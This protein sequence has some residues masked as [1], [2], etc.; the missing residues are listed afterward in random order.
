MNEYVNALMRPI[1]VLLL[2]RKGIFAL[3]QNAPAGRETREGTRGLCV[4]AQVSAKDPSATSSKLVGLMLLFVCVAA[5]PLQ[6]VEQL[7]S[8]LRDKMSERLNDPFSI[9]PLEIATM[10][11]R[12]FNFR[13]IV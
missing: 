11:L 12:H 4:W 2:I 13:Q 9:L 10:V 7:H 3:C 1:I 5:N 8:K 6:L